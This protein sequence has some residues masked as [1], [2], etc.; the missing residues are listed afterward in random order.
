[1]QI[2]DKELLL[3]G[4]APLH[5]EI[6]KQSPVPEYFVSSMGRVYSASTNKILKTNKKW[7]HHI[8]M[9]REGK[10]L[11]FLAHRWVAQA[12]I[13]NPENKPFI[14]HKNAIKSD[15]RVENLEWCTNKENM[16]HAGSLGLIKSPRHNKGRYGG[17]STSAKKVLKLSKQMVPICVYGSVLDAANELGVNVHW[18]RRRA[19][20]AA[21]SAGFTWVYLEIY[22]KNNDPSFDINSV[23][24]I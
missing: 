12:F 19:R 17:N 23:P 14:N 22:K 2:Q 6:W 15:N 8:S 4:C 1:M 20:I 24:N 3:I 7:Y 13:P 5:G 11:H 21:I 18:L 9:K 16:Q 10:T